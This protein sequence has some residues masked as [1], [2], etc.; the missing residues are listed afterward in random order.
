[1]ATK[2]EVRVFLTEFHQKMKIWEIRIRDDRGKNTQA[3]LDME[4]TPAQRIKIIEALIPDD[5]SE[6]PKTDTLNAG[7]PLWIFGRIVKKVEIYIKV[8]MGPPGRQVICISFHASEYPMD[9]PL[10]GT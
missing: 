8:S 5:Y 10:K 9:F 2:E 7:T 1:M 4:L 6:G 3:L